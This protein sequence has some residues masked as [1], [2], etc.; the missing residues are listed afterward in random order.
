M[1]AAGRASSG[2]APRIATATDRASSG[3]IEEVVDEV[4]CWVIEVACEGYRMSKRV[5][6]NV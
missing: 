5:D 2:V 6:R 3:A 4:V 1:I